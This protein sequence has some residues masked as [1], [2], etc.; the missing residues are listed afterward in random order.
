MHTCTPKCE[1]GR[2]VRTTRNIVM[3]MQHNMGYVAK[4]VT[5]KARF[6]CIV[7]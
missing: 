4:V 6:E 7:K 5:A 2:V 3:D 1:T